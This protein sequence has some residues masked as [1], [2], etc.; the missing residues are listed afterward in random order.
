MYTSCGLLHLM[1]GLSWGH[2]IHSGFRLHRLVINR[3]DN[4]AGSCWLDVA[5]IVIERRP[6]EWESL[7]PRASAGYLKL[8]KL[9]ACY[10][11]RRTDTQGHMNHRLVHNTFA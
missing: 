10:M 5:S 9:D 4:C 6:F 1:R 8:T 7:K 3:H 2:H 11:R